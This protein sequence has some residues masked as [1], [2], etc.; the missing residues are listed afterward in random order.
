MWKRVL[1][2]KLNDPEAS[3][4][5]KKTGKY[6]RPALIKTRRYKETAR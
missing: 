4:P 3:Y 1:R 6:T 2:K 5:S